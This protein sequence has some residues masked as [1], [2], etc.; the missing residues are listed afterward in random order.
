MR[1]A[2][3]VSFL[4]FDD[5]SMQETPDEME[6]NIERLA[7]VMANDG[8]PPVS[9]EDPS[10][11]PQAI[12]ITPADLPEMPQVIPMSPEQ[13]NPILPNAA[14][15]TE[16]SAGSDTTQ[17][18]SSP[19]PASL[20]ISSQLKIF[21]T[22]DDN[23]L[24]VPYAFVL[25]GSPSEHDD[26]ADTGEMRRSSP[27]RPVDLS[28]RIS[29]QSPVAT[30]SPVPFAVVSPSKAPET[31]GNTPP[32]LAYQTSAML[33]STS[34]R[35]ICIP[36]TEMDSP[37]PRS[38]RLDERPQRVDTPQ[39]RSSRLSQFTSTQRP[40]R[41]GSSP[42]ET[43]GIT[44]F[45]ST[46][47]PLIVGT[48]QPGPSMINQIQ[49]DSVQSTPSQSP[50]SKR[51]KPMSSDTDPIVIQLPVDHLH[52]GPSS[53]T[54]DEQTLVQ[55]MS[56]ENFLTSLSPALVYPGQRYLID[57]ITPIADLLADQRVQL[58]VVIDNEDDYSASLV[59]SQQSDG[60]MLRIE[61][62]NENVP[63]LSIA[64]LRPDDNYEQLQ[65]MEKAQADAV[66]PFSH[67][68]DERTGSQGVGGLGQNC[69]AIRLVDPGTVELPRANA[70]MVQRMEDQI[71][72]LFH[73]DIERRRMAAAGQV[74]NVLCVVN[75][76][77]DSSND[78]QRL[79][80]VPEDDEDQDM[81]HE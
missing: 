75:E 9:L 1:Q 51:P 38:S 2:Q 53:D 24:S 57:T 77:S 16:N 11:M 32:S 60:Q 79:E 40:L 62:R 35:P 14:E 73:M 72:F 67:R 50:E 76:C 43:S 48:P 69:V 78:E 4:L 56:V 61:P 29:P 8:F 80:E 17:R 37:Q 36:S 65:A 26:R 12:P 10:E 6:E 28:P 46:R 21:Q 74:G 70:E 41:V 81:Q 7:L 52:R 20:T 33:R 42:P 71:R 58:L 23:S 55:I 59:P 34:P 39:F 44:L 31:V 3:E 15:A 45:S 68:N 54:T 22:A 47:R 13:S 18:T 19:R 63:P 66:T 64:I 27:S 25:P 5:E 49:L 30:T